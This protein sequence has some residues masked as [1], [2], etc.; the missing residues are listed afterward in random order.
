[1]DCG[2]DDVIFLACAS[3]FGGGCGSFYLM[4][5]LDVNFNVLGLLAS[6]GM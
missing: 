4:L 3:R 6:G 1:M 2:I 5:Y